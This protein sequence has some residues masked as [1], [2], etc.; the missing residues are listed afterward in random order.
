MAFDDPTRARLRA[1]VSDARTLLTAECTRQL[2]QDYG[3]DPTTGEVVE[4]SA[5]PP[6]DDTRWETARLLRE[7]LAH[8]LATRCPFHKFATS[9]PAERL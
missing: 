6:L 1:F 7:T 8:Y 4:L 2:Q 5:L 3:M 9:N